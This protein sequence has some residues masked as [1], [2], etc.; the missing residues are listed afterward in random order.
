MVRE[1]T[2]AERRILHES[3]DHLLVSIGDSYSIILFDIW[4]YFLF[5]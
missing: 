1:S 5:H 2:A 3:I 4:F